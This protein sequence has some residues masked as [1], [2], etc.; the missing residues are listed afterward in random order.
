M[1]EADLA[2]GDLDQVTLAIQNALKPAISA[3]R[4]VA[5]KMNG[6]TLSEPEGGDTTD[7]VEEL[8]GDDVEDAGQGQSTDRQ[9]RVRRYK[10]PNI[11]TVDLQS[12]LSFADFIADK[13]IDSHHMRFLTVAA[14]FNLHRSTP[15]VTMHHVY[16][17]YRVAKWPTNLQDFAQPLRD[18]KARKLM[19]SGEER[20]S[21]VIN[22]V[23]LHEV[24]NITKK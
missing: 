9:P 5:P 8:L 1:L 19:D 18:L 2:E 20:G 11:V 12:P 10:T 15:A 14:W 7:D 24:E 4:L 17:C 3:P 22:H 6:A 21:F 23:G 16:T 13:N